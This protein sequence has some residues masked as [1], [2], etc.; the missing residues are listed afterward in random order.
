MLVNESVSATLDKLH[1][2]LLHASAA[3]ETLQAFV[4][5]GDLGGYGC[6]G[7]ALYLLRDTIDRDAETIEELLM[8]E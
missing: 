2:D 8:T 5:G 1:D 3:I 6:I 7:G 4:G